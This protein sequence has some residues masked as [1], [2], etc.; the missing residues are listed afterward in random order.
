MSTAQPIWHGEWTLDQLA[1]LTRNTLVDHLGIEFV[2]IAPDALKARLPVRRETAQRMGF[3]H[4]G[5]SLALAETVGSLASQMCID[6][7]THASL[8]LD[9]NANHVRPVPQGQHVIGIARPIHLGRQTHVWE[10]R[11]ETE[12][13]KL[14]CIARLTTA[15]QPRNKPGAGA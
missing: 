11:V 10:V 2:E 1:E 4:G 12:E 3:L 5:A 13:G 8:G 9:L 15:I 14:A 7:E 6:R